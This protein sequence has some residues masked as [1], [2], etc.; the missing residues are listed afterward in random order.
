MTDA[1]PK[2]HAT[3]QLDSTLTSNREPPRSYASL[4][5]A[6]PTSVSVPCNLRAN[7]GSGLSSHAFLMSPIKAAR[8]EKLDY[9]FVPGQSLILSSLWAPL[10]APDDLF[11]RVPEAGAGS[12]HGPL[13]KHRFFFFLAQ[14]HSL[15]T[16]LVRAYPELSQ[17]S[18]F[19]VTV[20]TP[21]TDLWDG[22]VQMAG[23][24]RV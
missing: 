11:H 17:E 13:P 2:P 16:D 15:R 18:W 3:S 19:L 24:R 21:Q 1:E 12:T 4:C 10:Q 22:I 23:P 5:P 6:T 14:K 7:L 9:C 8:P 20:V